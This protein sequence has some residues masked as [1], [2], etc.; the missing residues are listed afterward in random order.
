MKNLRI[1]RFSRN[2]LAG[3]L[4]LTPL[5]L[6]GPIPTTVI[7][8]RPSEIAKAAEQVVVGTDRRASCRER[9]F[10]PV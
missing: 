4:S 10:V 6:A 2:L 9:V 1:P 5:A 3:A 8:L 7:P